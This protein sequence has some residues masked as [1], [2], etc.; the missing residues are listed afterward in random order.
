MLDI[1][2]YVIILAFVVWEC[3]A[4]WVFRNKSGH[5]LSNRVEWLER[6]GGWPVR[7]LVIAALIALGVHWQGVF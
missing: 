6:E 5:T 3:L 1:I 4:H 7:A 2:L